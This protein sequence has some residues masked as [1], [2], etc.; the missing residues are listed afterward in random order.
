M[1]LNDKNKGGGVYN[2]GN[3][4]LDD[5]ANWCNDIEY[6]NLLVSFDGGDIG[7]KYFPLDKY[8]KITNDTGISNFRCQMTKTK[9]PKKILK[10]SESLYVKEFKVN[11]L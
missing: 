3:F 6:C 7:E 1:F 8:K 4:N 5:F 2:S 9:E 10:T 11:K